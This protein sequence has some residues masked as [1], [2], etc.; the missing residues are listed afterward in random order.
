V[1]TNDVNVARTMLAVHVPQSWPTGLFC[2]NCRQRH[3]CRTRRWGREI[4]W[5]AGWT[6]AEIEALDRRAGPWS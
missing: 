5:T 6:E 1:T 2:G 3:P 4:L